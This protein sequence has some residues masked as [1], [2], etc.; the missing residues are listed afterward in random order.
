MTDN[1]ENITKLLFITKALEVCEYGKPFFYTSGKLG[2]YY[3]N[4]HYLYGS[5]NEADEVLEIMATYKNKEEDLPLVLKEKIMQQYNA[6]NIF[7]QVID[8]LLNISKKFD[9][10]FISGG[11]RRDFFFSIPL[12]V[13]LNK[14]H[15]SIFKS[16][17]VYLSSSSF[18]ECSKEGEFDLKGK[19]SLHVADLVTEA[20]SYFRN[21]IPALNKLQAL[22]QESIAV[23]D[24]NQGGADALKNAGINLTTPVSITKE[25]FSSSMAE[26]YI[27]KNQY[28]M[29]ESFIDNPDKFIIDFLKENPNFLQEQLAA[30]GKSRERALR[31]IENGYNKSEK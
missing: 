26:G 17:A 19:T 1:S 3:I 22:I 2:P 12:A 16:G 23:I 28:L 14:P 11:E 8:L 31:C 6:N 20:S 25:F 9:F 13:L 15:L 30:G 29:V 4:T 24:R 7:K 27:S 21:W 18:N 5:K 10:D